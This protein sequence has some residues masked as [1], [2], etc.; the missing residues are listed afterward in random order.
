MIV[1][2]SWRPDGKELYYLS[3][4]GAMMAV[5]ITVSGGGQYGVAPDGRFL[6]NTERDSTATCRRHAEH[7]AAELAG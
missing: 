1:I 6:I 3:P 5:P 2:F 7:A 4:A